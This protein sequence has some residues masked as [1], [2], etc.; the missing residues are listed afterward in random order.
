MAGCSSFSGAYSLVIAPHEVTPVILKARPS[1]TLDVLRL[2]IANMSTKAAHRKPRIGRLPYLSAAPFYFG[3][4]SEAEHFEVIVAPPRQLAHLA[5]QGEIDAACFSLTDVF[6][7]NRSFEPLGT[8]GLTVA[9]HGQP[10][11]PLLLARVAETLLGQVPIGIPQEAAMAPALL[12]VLFREVF[13]VPAPEYVPLTPDRRPLAGFIV[14]G[15]AAIEAIHHPP[16]GFDHVRNL[17]TEWQN[18]T[19]LPLVFGRWMVRK[20]MS[21]E[22]KAQIEHMIATALS[23]AA[24]HTKEKVAAAL[25]QTSPYSWDL[26]AAA[27]VLQQFD[28]DLKDIHQQSIRRFRQEQRPKRQRTPLWLQK[29]MLD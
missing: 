15:D 11:G 12:N 29:D 22:S 17:A 28:Y 16:R 19:G 2:M 27:K 23:K 20:E 5:R 6:R 25:L 21:A 7:L 24:R 13:K 14:I 18:W 4:G 1:L 26:K 3:W 10:P 9:K 8:F